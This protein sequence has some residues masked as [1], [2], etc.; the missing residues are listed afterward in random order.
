M[1]GPS[2]HL[3]WDKEMACRDGT[4]YPDRWRESRAIPLAHEFERIRA[5]VGKPMT[6]LSAYRTAQYNAR[7]PGAAKSSQHV[8]G[9]ALDLRP[10]QGMRVAQ[11]LTAVLG[12][13]RRGDSRIRGVGEYTWGVH[14]DIR[15]GDRLARWS[16]SKPVQVAKGRSV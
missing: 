7:I 15:P 2:P 14:V 1:Q 5:A 3:S 12:V 16:G 8:Q 10:P 9:R 4:P 11:L 6:V 13:A